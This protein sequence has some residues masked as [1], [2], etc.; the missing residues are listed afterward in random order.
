MRRLAGAVSSSFTDKEAYEIFRSVNIS[1]AVSLE[2]GLV[3]LIYDVRGRL[4]L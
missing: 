3:V 4:P 2:Q 1:L